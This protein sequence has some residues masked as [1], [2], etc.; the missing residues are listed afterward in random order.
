MGLNWEYIKPSYILEAKDFHIS[1]TKDTSALHPGFPPARIEDL[2]E[3]AL[4]VERKDRYYIL[5][6]DWRKEY[7]EVFHLGLAACIKVFEENKE[8]AKSA[9]GNR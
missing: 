7:E 6:G 5:K 2:Q 9:W 1:Y 8:N 4:Y 3:T